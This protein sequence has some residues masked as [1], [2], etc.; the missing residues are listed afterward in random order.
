MGYKKSEKMHTQR[1]YATCPKG[2]SKMKRCMPK[3][4]MP[5]APKGMSKIKDAC[6][7]KVCHMLTRHVKKNSIVHVHEK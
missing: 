4:G 3:E 2:M 5:H 7:K 1:R 6:P